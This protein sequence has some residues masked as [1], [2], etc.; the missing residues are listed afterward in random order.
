ML[1]D[2]E[3]EKLH[4]QIAQMIAETVKTQA[5]TEKIRK[6]LK[7]YEI[8]LLISGSVAFTALIAVL[9]KVFF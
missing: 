1:T 6:D 7:W 9:T 5:E 8:V 4:A 3:L 2:L